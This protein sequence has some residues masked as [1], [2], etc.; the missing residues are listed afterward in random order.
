MKLTDMTIRWQRGSYVCLYEVHQR[1]RLVVV[2]IVVYS[3]Q[4]PITY[5]FSHLYTVTVHNKQRDEM[6]RIIINTSPLSKALFTLSQKTFL[7]L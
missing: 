4:G 5:I 3:F 6:L 2:V 1:T 7:P